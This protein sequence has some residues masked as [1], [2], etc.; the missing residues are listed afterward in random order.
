LLPHSM[1]YW[2]VHGCAPQLP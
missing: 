2:W 1:L